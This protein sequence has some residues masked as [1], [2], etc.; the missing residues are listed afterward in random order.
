MAAAAT[1]ESGDVSASATN[2]LGTP[3][4][5]CCRDPV[6][7]FYRDG[8]CH[9]GPLDSGRHVVCARVTQAFLEYSKA[10]GNDLMTPM[11]AYGFPGLKDGD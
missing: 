5:C 6:T 10:K 2:V 7:G 8:F 9:T 11:P 1:N 3:L 4:Q